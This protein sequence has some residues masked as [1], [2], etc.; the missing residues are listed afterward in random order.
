LLS[1]TQS[2]VSSTR[3][4]VLRQY[5]TESHL[6]SDCNVID[7][8]LPKRDGAVF[9]HIYDRPWGARWA[10]WYARRDQYACVELLDWFET[11]TE[12]VECARKFAA[13]TGAEL[14][15]DDGKGGAA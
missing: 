5:K 1:R 14:V 3:D 12:A 15:E 2:S 6:M 4:P 7:F 8:P 10:T 13:R 11:R 9:V